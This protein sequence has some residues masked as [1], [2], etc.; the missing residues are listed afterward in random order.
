MAGEPS[1]SSFA[2]W[3]TRCRAG[4]GPPPQVGPDS[5]EAEDEALAGRIWHEE[6]ALA[7]VTH[8][9]RFSTRI[10]AT[11]PDQLLS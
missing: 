11:W 5:K 8:L 4:A 2:Q 9:D 3:L 7:G 1:V 6:R 10:A